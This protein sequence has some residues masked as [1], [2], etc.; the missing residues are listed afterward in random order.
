MTGLAGASMETIDPYVLRSLADAQPDM[1][2]SDADPLE[3]EAH[4]AL[5]GSETTELVVVGA[6]YTGLWTALLAK[7]A[8]PE[9]D[10]VIIEQRETGAGAS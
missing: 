7:E 10:V 4:S 1:Y 8:N 2:W 9:R 6:G 5:I 3:T